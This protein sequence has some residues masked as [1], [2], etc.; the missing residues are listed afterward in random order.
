MVSGVNVGMHPIHGVS[1]QSFY[2]INIEVKLSH[3]K[4]MCDIL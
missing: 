3:W 2:M 4:L 1:V